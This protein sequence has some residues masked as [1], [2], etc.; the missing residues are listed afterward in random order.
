MVVVL[1]L[2]VAYVLVYLFLLMV[3]ARVVMGWVLAYSRRWQPGRA[4][5]AS[6][7]TVWTVTD[8]PLKALGRVIPPIPI[9][10]LRIDIAAL[11]LLV[12]L[13]VLFAVLGN[14]IKGLSGS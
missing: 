12:I 7:E 4:A 5:A 10:N 14:L 2:Q 8:P 3:L 1:V 11:V 9:G 13:F 6:L